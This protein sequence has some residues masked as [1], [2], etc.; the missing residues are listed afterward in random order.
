M[1]QDSKKR[2]SDFTDDKD[3]VLHQITDDLENAICEES[4]GIESAL[5]DIENALCELTEE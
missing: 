2:L 4:E 3:A 5:A 1:I